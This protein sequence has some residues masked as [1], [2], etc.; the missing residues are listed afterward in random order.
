[1]GLNYSI[2]VIGFL[3]GANFLAPDYNFAAVRAFSSLVGWVQSKFTT[4]NDQYYL[5]YFCAKVD[6]T[7]S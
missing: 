3:L 1:M 5:Y 6:V 4:L 7:E 2:Y